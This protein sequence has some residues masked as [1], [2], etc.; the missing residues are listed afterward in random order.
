M[1]Y[2]TTHYYLGVGIQLLV[3]SWGMIEGVWFPIPKHNLE[4]KHSVRPSLVGDIVRGAEP[5]T[6]RHHRQGLEPAPA[7]PPVEY[8]QQASMTQ[9]V[10][11]WFEGVVHTLWYG[12]K[13]PTEKGMVQ[14]W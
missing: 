10:Q 13:V 7:I 6:T 9:M 14:R 3:A 11:R 8:V 2:K 5:I 12:D 1:S 4:P